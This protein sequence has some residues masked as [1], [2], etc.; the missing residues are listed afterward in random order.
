MSETV[1]EF[2]LRPAA[3]SGEARVLEIRDFGSAK[4]VILDRTVFYPEGGGQPCDLGTLGGMAV[5]GVAEEGS[6]VLHRIEGEL[7]F[8]VGDIVTM[9][10]DAARR[11][12]H[13]Q[14]HSGQHLLSAILEREYGVHTISFHLGAAYSTI[15]VSRDSMDASMIESIEKAA[16]S[17]IV[18]DRPYIVHCCPPEDAHSFPIR[19]KLPAGETRIT[20][21]EIDGYDWV[22]CCGT[23]VASASALRVFK[24]LNTERYKGNTRIYFAAGDRAVA[25]L[26]KHFGMLKDV[27]GQLGTS[28]EES[29]AKLATA[30]R[31]AGILEGE[32][33]LLIRERAS[34][35]I[36]LAL[37]SSDLAGGRLLR[38]NYDD[39][40]AD[41]AMETVKA[42]VTRG[43]SVIALSMPDRTVCVMR[44]SGQPD[45]PIALGAALKPMLQEFEGRG[46]GGLGNFRAV[47]QSA[48]DAEGFAD[49]AAS[50]LN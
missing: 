24:I 3:V 22:A 21:V 13:S 48:S 9:T 29:P 27:A 6:V 7:P 5:A 43:F 44:P 33:N 2:Y 14:Q 31:R 1:K 37:Q 26:G 50:F 36:D 35:E 28:P 25:L 38:F 10:I 41:T 39:R 32:R 42:G 18:G 15:D 12:D 49:K 8:A 16:E 17:F 34:M 46:G 45:K 19:K 20:I 23:H 47:F 11:R 30:L 40:D 4:D